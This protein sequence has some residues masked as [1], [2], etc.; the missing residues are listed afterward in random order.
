MGSAIPGS[1]DAI[2][3]VSSSGLGTKLSGFNEWETPKKSES[4]ELRAWGGGVKRPTQPGLS[5]SN[6]PPLSLEVC[7]KYC[8]AETN[9]TAGAWQGWHQG[10][11]KC[12]SELAVIMGREQVIHYVVWNPACAVDHWF[13]RRMS[14]RAPL[15]KCHCYHYLVGPN[16]ARS[17]FAQNWD[18]ALVMCQLQANVLHWPLDWR[19]LCSLCGSLPP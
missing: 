4:S 17:P 3:Y 16:P 19:F 5:K 1:I 8:K 9:P 7:A 15:I 18:F 12:E 11:Q 14:D 6:K 13:L 10:I 2:A